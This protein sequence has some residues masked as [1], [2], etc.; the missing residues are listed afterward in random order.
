MERNKGTQEMLSGNLKTFVPSCIVILLAKTPSFHPFGLVKLNN[1][2]TFVV[3]AMSDLVSD[4]DSDASVV[5]RLG[6]V[7]AVEQWL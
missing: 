3:E 1:V 4:H 2:P 6:E 5:E 7:L